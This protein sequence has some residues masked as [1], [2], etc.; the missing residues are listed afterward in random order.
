MCLLK[1]DTEA[2]RQTDRQTYISEIGR[3]LPSTLEQF[4]LLGHL[5]KKPS[6]RGGKSM[7]SG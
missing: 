4:L 2:G 7:A 6:V 1:R 3:L 5:P